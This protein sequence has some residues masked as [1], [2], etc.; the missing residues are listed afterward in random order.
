M[1]TKPQPSNKQLYKKARKHTRSLRR[2][3]LI[4]RAR[5]LI[6]GVFA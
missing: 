5:S 4:A 6:A 2:A 3:L 1:N